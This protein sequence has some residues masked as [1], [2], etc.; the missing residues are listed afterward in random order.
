M[1]VPDCA[2]LFRRLLGDTRVPRRA[3]A[4]LALLLA[5]LVSP[6]DIV[7]DFIPLVGQLDDAVVAAIA[8]AYVVRVSGEDVIAELWPGSE[9]GLAV[10][11]ALARR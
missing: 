11:M 6:I 3:K 9:R 8:V 2:L 4:V 5:S 10:V 1:F 7:P